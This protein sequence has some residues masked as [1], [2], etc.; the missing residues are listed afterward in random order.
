MPAWPLVLLLQG[1]TDAAIAAT[2]CAASLRSQNRTNADALYKAWQFAVAKGE[3]RADAAGAFPAASKKV[4]PVFA[5]CAADPDSV[6]LG[7]RC[8]C[9]TGSGTTRSSRTIWRNITACANG[10]SISPMAS[11]IASRTVNEANVRGAVE[12]RN[13]V[14]SQI[15]V[16]ASTIFSPKKRWKSCGAIAGAPPSG[17]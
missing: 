8:R 1:R 6:S 12:Q 9:R 13:S 3:G 16:S 4:F 17:G 14:L 10:N 7:R 11:R 2:I 5:A 15:I